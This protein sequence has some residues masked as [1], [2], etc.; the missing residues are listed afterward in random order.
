M[1]KNLREWTV[2]V[3]FAADNDLTPF[4]L[5]NLAQ[6]LMVGATDKV[7]VL[8]QIDLLDPIT[9]TKRY[10]LLETGGCA[11][12]TIPEANTGSVQDF[13]S[14]VEWGTKA[15]H[16]AER[17]LVIIWGH[18]N[19]VDDDEDNERDAL[20]DFLP[21]PDEIVTTGIFAGTPIASPL[22][23]G[24]LA[25]VADIG[26]D[27]NPH[28]VK[29]NDLLENRHLGQSKPG[30][31]QL[32]ALTTRELGRALAGAKEKLKGK[33]NVFGMDACLMGMVE[34]ARQI[35][36]SVQ[37]MVASQ[38]TIPDTSW[39]YDKILK[40]LVQRPTMSERELATLLVDKYIESYQDHNEEPVALSACDLRK[41]PGLV[42]AVNKLGRAINSVLTIPELR[43]ALVRARRR[44]L[45]F[46]IRDY[47]DLS[48]LCRVL[49]DTMAE[50]TVKAVDTKAA[51]DEI[52]EACKRVMGE[53]HGADQTGFVV[54]AGNNSAPGGLL[55]NARGVS[56]Y[57][58]IIS[59]LYSRLLISDE[60]RWSEFLRDYSHSCLTKPVSNQPIAPAPNA[61]V[62]GTASTSSE[63]NN[64]H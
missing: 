33:I 51:R 44:A 8:A 61:F 27:L 36:D 50:V 42:A 16:Q 20:A 48:D 64:V 34:V 41:T 1:S 38:Q 10:T 46:F 26:L 31:L 58:P 53:I 21:Q 63:S 62:V 60:T 37:L 52:I 24:N 19:G 3:Y 56:I 43:R 23:L 18:G 17:Y 11:E 30:T 2:M 59:T 14:F 12:E 35:S 55:E 25:N 4:A 7:H 15:E 9:P 54:A 5:K 39:P 32:D 6:M 57:F 40:E 45:S 49:Q 28:P 22:P 29:S 13:I 47:V